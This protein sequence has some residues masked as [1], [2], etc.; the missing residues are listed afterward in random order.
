MRAL[1]GLA[2]AAVFVSGLAL[3]EQPGSAPGK[4][5]KDDGDTIVCKREQFV[6]SIIP[7]RICMT[8]AQWEEGAINAKRALDEKYMWDSPKELA[9]NTGG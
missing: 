4:A 1:I 5:H 9:G 7:R 8:K 3:A 2:A 6:G